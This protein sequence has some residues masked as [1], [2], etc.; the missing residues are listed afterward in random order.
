MGGTLIGGFLRPP[1]P[2]GSFGNVPAGD[3]APAITT[4]PASQAVATG[5]SVTLSVVATGTPTPNF[6]WF[7]NDRPISGANSASYTINSAQI[8]DAGSYVVALANPAGFVVSTPALLGVAKANAVT[9]TT[10]PANQTVNAGANV[11]FAVAATGTALTYQWQFNDHNIAGATSP[12]LAINTVGPTAAGTFTAVI[13]DATG[14]EAVEPAT[15]TVVT[16]ARLANLSVRGLVGSASERL[17]VGFV[18]GGSD[19]KSILLRGVGPTLTTFGVTGVL[20]TPDLTLYSG[21]GKTLDSNSTWG[22]TSALTAVFAQ[23]GAFPL[24]A[25]SADAA[26]LESLSSGGYTAAITG[27]SNSTGVALAELYDADTAA[28]PTASLVNI[29]GRAYVTGGSGVLTAGFSI[30]GTTSET[31]LVR[32]IGPGLK[33]FGVGNALSATVVTLYDSSQNPILSNA[34]WGGD[35]SINAA[36]NLVGAFSLDPNAKDSALLVTLAPGGYT[37]QVTGANGSNGEGLAEIYEVK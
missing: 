2:S 23:V 3:V 9:V 15:L 34:G 22:G 29:S 32:G 19:Q 25:T 36:G 13:S 16:N 20:A 18:I 35:P 5:S 14:V 7:R 8:S 17:T 4:Q 24:P 31:V 28:S 30:S 1:G 12:T 37:V 21:Q 26:L 6:Q 33:A 10:A 11:T 27:L